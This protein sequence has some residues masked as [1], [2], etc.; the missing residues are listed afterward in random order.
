LPPSIDYIEMP[1][2]I[3]GQYQYF[4]EA[5]MIKLRAVGCPFAFGSLEETVADYVKAY[6]LETDPYL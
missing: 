1:E 2:A 6:L 5:K 3:R 4:T